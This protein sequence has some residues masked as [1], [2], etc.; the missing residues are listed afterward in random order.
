[1]RIY[2]PAEFNLVFDCPVLVDAT[3]TAID[4][5]TYTLPNIQA[6]E[7][8]IQLTDIPHTAGLDESNK[9]GNLPAEG[10]VRR[11]EVGTLTGTATWHISVSIASRPR[12][13]MSPGAN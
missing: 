13:K 6:L 10:T 5:Q 12:M 4:Y 3:M 8:N 11:L 9:R 2:D 7:R 1:M